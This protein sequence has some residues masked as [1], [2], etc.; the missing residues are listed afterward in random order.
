MHKL[1]LYADDIIFNLTRGISTPDNKQLDI[2]ATFQDMNEMSVKLAKHWKM[3]YNG[4]HS[5]EELWS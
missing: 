4:L 5:L 2:M 1:A 3:Q